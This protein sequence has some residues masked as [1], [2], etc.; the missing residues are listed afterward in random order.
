MGFSSFRLPSHT[1][2]S[3]FLSL[4]SLHILFSPFLSPLLPS[5]FFT[6]CYFPLQLACYTF[7]SLLSFS[8]PPPFI[9]FSF[10][11][12]LSALRHLILHLLLLFSFHPSLYF[13]LPPSFL[14][15]YHHHYHHPPPPPLTSALPLTVVSPG[16]RNSVCPANEVSLLLTKTHRHSKREIAHGTREEFKTSR[17]EEKLPGGDD[18]RGVAGVIDVFTA[19]GGSEKGSGKK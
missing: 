10:P 2:N 17:R 16:G 3:P 19:P 12:F 5:T 15:H 6:S 18:T 13:T 8:S 1:S 4:S 11:T 7:F 9:S 14:Q